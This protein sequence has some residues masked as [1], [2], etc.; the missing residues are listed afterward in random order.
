VTLAQMAVPLRRSHP[1]FPL[2]AAPRAVAGH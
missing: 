2:L 1:E